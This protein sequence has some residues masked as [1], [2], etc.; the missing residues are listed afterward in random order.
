MDADSFQRGVNSAGDGQELV[1]RDA[2]QNS[3]EPQISLEPFLPPAPGL[4]TSSPVFFAVL[5]TS[6]LASLARSATPLR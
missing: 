6:A 3:H 5:A 1:L 2:L 4:G